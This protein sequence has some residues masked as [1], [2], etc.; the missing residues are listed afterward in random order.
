MLQVSERLPAASSTSHWA[1]KFK[2]FTP[3]AVADTLLC[4]TIQ[5]HVSHCTT[6]ALAC[7]ICQFLRI[8]WGVSGSL[9]FGA[10]LPTRC[11]YRGGKR[12]SS[13]VT[14]C[15]LVVVACHD[16]PRN[17]LTIPC[18]TMRAA[19]GFCDPGP[20]ISKTPSTS[21]GASRTPAP[22]PTSSPS[23]SPTKSTSTSQC[24]GSPLL[25][26]QNKKEEIGKRT[27]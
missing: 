8:L 1:G 16:S 12:L 3:N 25:C 21:Q 6:C 27:G 2:C 24:C 22:S 4:V 17:L 26:G 20:G 5:F 18:V 15:V 9:R 7:V 14:R 23:A 19:Y 10:R 13:S 11:D